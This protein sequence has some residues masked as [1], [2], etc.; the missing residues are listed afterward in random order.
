MKR[1]IGVALA[2]LV[3]VLTLWAWR[4]RQAPGSEGF[5]EYAMLQPSDIPTTIAAGRDG[6]IWF[7]LDFSDAIGVLR[8][9]KMQR[10][11]KGKDNVEPIG[12]AVDANGAAWYTDPPSI[13]ISRIVPSGQ[14]ASYPLGTPIARLGRL[15]VA[16]DGAVWFAESTSYSITRLKD[17]VLKR[18]VIKSIRGGPYGV[19]VDAQGTVWGTLQSG[20]ALVR[21]SGADEMTEFEIPTHGASPSDVAVDSKGRVW[22]L[23]FRANK[24]GRFEDGKFYEI[25]VPGSAGLTGLAIA[26]DGSVWFGMLREHSLGRLRDGKITTYA[27]PRPNARPY[28]I[29]IDASGNVWYADIT[30]YVGNLPAARAQKY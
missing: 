26:P 17:G 11:P 23:E 14:I 13:E 10:L 6:S 16:P 18:N 3:V 25:D 4:A 20:N 12:L 7:T 19:A 9:G 5:H 27:L 8:E 22:F 1:I 24:I 29:A 30:G 15:A 21:I 2:L 28:S